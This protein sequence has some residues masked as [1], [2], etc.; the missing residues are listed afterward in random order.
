MEEFSD[1][2]KEVE[3]TNSAYRRVVTNELDQ[4][5]IRDC[6]LPEISDVTGYQD[7]HESDNSS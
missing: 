3:S 4:R 6:R 5:I 2:H 7:K 1:S